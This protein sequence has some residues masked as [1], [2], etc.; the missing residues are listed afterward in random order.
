MCD[1]EFKA[2]WIW[3]DIRGMNI[4]ENGIHRG[5]EY[6]GRVYCNVHPEGLPLE[7]WKHD[8]MS[9]YGRLEYEYIVIF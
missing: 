2:I 4:S 5:V 8:F 1:K 6:N 3:S 9:R 7:V